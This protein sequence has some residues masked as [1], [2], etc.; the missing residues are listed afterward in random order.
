MQSLTSFK[1]SASLFFSYGICQRMIA[2]LT[3]KKD[4]IELNTLENSFAGSGAGIIASLVLC[5]SEVIK[6]RLQAARELKNS[7][8]MYY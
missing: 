6:C 1:A 8:H 7:T 3:N 5:P 4:I 2:N